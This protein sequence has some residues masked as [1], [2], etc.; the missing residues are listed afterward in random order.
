MDIDEFLSPV[1]CVIPYL[2]LYSG[3]ISSP[4]SV[5][6]ER[7]CSLLRCISIAKKNM[8]SVIIP[9]DSGPPTRRAHKKS[10]KGCRIC[11]ERKLKVRISS[12]VIQYDP[13]LRRQCDEVKP[14]CGNCER[15]FVKIRSCDWSQP[16]PT[17]S[18]PRGGQSKGGSSQSASSASTSQ[19]E[20]EWDWRVALPRSLKAELLD[21]F[22][23]YPESR[24]QGIDV[25]MKYCMFI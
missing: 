18:S 7:S 3:R 22:Q 15:R 17:D 24:V 4:L 21:P 5:F 8:F 13:Y 10:R 1:T 12:I 9:P 23:T 16:T 25:L 14:V 19:S 20:M 6:L 11:K 2:D